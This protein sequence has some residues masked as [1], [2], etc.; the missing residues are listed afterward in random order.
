MSII[1]IVFF[2]FVRSVDSKLYNIVAK[3][4]VFI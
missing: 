2:I 3:P 4:S 1:Y